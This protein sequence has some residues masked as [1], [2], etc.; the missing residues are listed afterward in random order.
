MAYIR[1]GGAKDFNTYDTLMNTYATGT[2]PATQTYTT[3]K[4]YKFIIVDATL[5]SD[6]S[7]TLGYANITVSKGTLVKDLYKNHYNNY[8]VTTSNRIKVFKDCDAG[9]VIQV[10]SAT[11]SKNSLINAIGIV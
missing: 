2:P 9:A 3:T 1:S 4:K 5:S 8:Y 7:T 11:N 6:V 10:S